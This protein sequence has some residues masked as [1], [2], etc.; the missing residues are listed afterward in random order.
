MKL[1]QW[2]CQAKYKNSNKIAMKKE[3]NHIYNNNEKNSNKQCWQTYKQW[4]L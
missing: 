4:V 1:E 2:E 3:N